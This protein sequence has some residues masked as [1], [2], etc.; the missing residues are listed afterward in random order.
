[1]NKMQI[2]ELLFKEG[3][4]SK[5]FSIIRQQAEKLGYSYRWLLPQLK[6]RFLV[7]LIL[8]VILFSG[9]VYTINI[10]TQENLVSYSITLFTGFTIFYL[11][12]PL[13]PAYKAFKVLRKH[14]YIL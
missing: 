13:N 10:G 8:I 7:A 12:I 2:E 3:F 9:L 6:K 4:T 5:E 1:M 14:F 11:F